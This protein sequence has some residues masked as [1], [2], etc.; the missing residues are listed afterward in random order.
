MQDDEW[1]IDAKL[2]LKKMPDSHMKRHEDKLN[3]GIPDVSFGLKGY[4]KLIAEINMGQ[5]MDP[6]NPLD[7]IRLVRGSMKAK[8]AIEKSRPTR[9]NKELLE[10]CESIGNE[11]QIVLEDWMFQETGRISKGLIHEHMKNMCDALRI[12]EDDLFEYVHEHTPGILVDV[13]QIL[14]SYGSDFLMLTL[15]LTESNIRKYSF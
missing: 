2:K 8:P 1:L 11:I 10:L 6:Q 5:T 12:S 13:G 14:Q 4:R 9:V 7:E 15:R 3:F